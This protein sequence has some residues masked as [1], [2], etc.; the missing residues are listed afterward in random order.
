MSVVDARRALD[1]V[2]LTYRVIYRLSA[3]AEPGAV[4]DTDPPEGRRVPVDTEVTLVVAAPQPSSPAVSTSATP[5]QAG[6]QT[7][8]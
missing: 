6:D 3:S 2:G 8:R 4:I 1:R 5:D 7:P